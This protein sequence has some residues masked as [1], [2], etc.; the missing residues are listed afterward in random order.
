[1]NEC[2]IGLGSNLGDRLSY[3]LRAVKLLS[4]TNIKIEKISSVFETAPQ[5]FLQQPKFLNCILQISTTL[6]PLE[7]LNICQSI[8]AII[9]KNKT[10]AFGPRNID[11]DI[12]MFN[13]EKVNMPNLVIPHPRMT[14]R[15]FVLTPLY[16]IA[17]NSIINGNDIKNLL[18]KCSDQDVVKF[19]NN[20]VFYE[21]L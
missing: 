15:N 10:I 8:E 21:V 1:M 18:E 14:S 11:I 19:C 12:L 2:Y 7:L 16:E 20:S 17:P 5:N 4:E 3:L 6:Q 9:G 13:D